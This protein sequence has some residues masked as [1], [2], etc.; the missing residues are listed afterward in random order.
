MALE[1]RCHYSIKLFYE[2]GLG[3]LSYCFDGLN[4]CYISNLFSGVCVY[5]YISVVEICRYNVKTVD[6]F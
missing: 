6:N 3:K 5:I 1:G 2:G 4:S